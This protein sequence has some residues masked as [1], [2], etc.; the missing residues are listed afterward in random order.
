M[1]NKKILAAGAAG[2]IIIAATVI[3]LDRQKETPVTA[4]ELSFSPSA[5]EYQAGSVFPVDIMANS[6]GKLIAGA[7][8]IINYDPEILESK[9]QNGLRIQRTFC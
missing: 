2:I 9:E 5:G 7:D 8:I 3:L 1:S 4:G 6:N